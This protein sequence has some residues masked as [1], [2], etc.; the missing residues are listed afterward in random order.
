M[1]AVRGFPG[2]AFLAPL[3][4][5]AG[6]SCDPG[7]VTLFQP[8]QDSGPASPVV[9]VT[10][11][12]PDWSPA[13]ES[14][15]HYLRFD[16][17][18]FKWETASTDAEGRLVLKLQPGWLYWI[19]AEHH[20]VTR[21]VLAGGE[22]LWAA[23]G[24]SL[25]VEI[26]LNAPRTSGVVISEVYM[27]FPETWETGGQGYQFGQYLELSNLGEEVVFL[28]G[29]IIGKAYDWWF[30]GA[31][32]GHHP[33]A[34]TEP[35]RNDPAGI[36]SPAMWRIPGSGVEH[37]LLPGEAALIAV[38][39]ADH[40]HIHP[41]LLDLSAA[42]FEF[43]WQGYA[44]NPSAANLQYLGPSPGREFTSFGGVVPF[45]FVASALDHR[46]FR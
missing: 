25:E 6:A 8:L 29:M 44:D 14:L 9:E 18:D 40:R 17:S 28:D 45:W 41:S 5:V 24:D 22:R 13:P 20:D 30:N 43:G 31:Q 12:L 35:M 42:R 32:H 16:R 36:W 11:L 27:K 38:L 4:L 23:D 37:A 2:A 3:A 1:V 26:R 21:G 39:A 33:C 15:V 7:S 19:A 46:R 10:V 34:V